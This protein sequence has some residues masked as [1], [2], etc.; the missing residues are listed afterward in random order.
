L[1]FCYTMM[2]M[3]MGWNYSLNCAHQGAYCSSPQVIYEYGEQWCNDIDRENSWFVRMAILQAV[4]YSTSGV[5]GKE[6][7]KFGLRNI[8]FIFRRVV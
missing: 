4:M 7:Y 1:L 5:T 2:I 8:S 6:N 3:S